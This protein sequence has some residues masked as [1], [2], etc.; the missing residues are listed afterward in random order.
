MA[1]ILTRGQTCALAD[2]KKDLGEEQ[3]LEGATVST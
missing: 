3:V 2:G 1:G